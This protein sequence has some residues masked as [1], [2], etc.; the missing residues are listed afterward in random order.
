MD[1]PN[2]LSRMKF[3]VCMLLLLFSVWCQSGVLSFTQSDIPFLLGCCGLGISCPLLHYTCS[4]GC[5]DP[6][7]LCSQCALNHH[8]ISFG[9]CSPHYSCFSTTAALRP[10]SSRI[11]RLQVNSIPPL[12]TSNCTMINLK[13]FQTIASILKK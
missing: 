2:V 4:P 1:D 7:D 3:K 9:F 10:Q 12:L 8:F 5:S 13:P 6:N 11:I